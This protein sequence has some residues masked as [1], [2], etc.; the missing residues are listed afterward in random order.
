MDVM[1]GEV[2]RLLQLADHSIVPITWQVPR[3]SY[4]KFH[5]DIFPDT[6]GPVASM[7]PT[8]W[9][10]GDNQAPALI[11]LE[12]AKRSGEMTVFSASLS[13]KTFSHPSITVTDSQTEK[14]QPRKSL[15]VKKKEPVKLRESA[16]DDV[17][18]VVTVEMRDVED[19][20]FLLPQ[21]RPRSSSFRASVKTPKFGRTTKFKHLKVCDIYIPTVSQSQ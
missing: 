2:A 10:G 4:D 5:A 7:G 18:G 3:K 16:N 19:D 1:K 6:W 12:P 9:M 14:I 11:S 21:I 8:E 20:S 13:G 15:S 17:D